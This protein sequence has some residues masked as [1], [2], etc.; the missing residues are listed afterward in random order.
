M[1]YA[2]VSNIKESVSKAEFA[3]GIFLDIRTA[4][5]SLMERVENSVLVFNNGTSQGGV[6]SA[7]LWNLFMNQLFQFIDQRT[8]HT[9]AYVDDMVLLAQGY[10][11]R[12]HQN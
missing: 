1:L 9:Q 10:D 3:L 7:L 5:D 12:T 6:L 11:L 8:D 2:L 4:F